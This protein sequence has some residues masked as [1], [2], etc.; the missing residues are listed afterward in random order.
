MLG[1]Y[2]YDT[3]NQTFVGTAASVHKLSQPFPPVNA[4]TQNCNAFDRN[5]SNA[6]N[7]FCCCIL[8]SVPLIFSVKRTTVTIVSPLLTITCPVPTVRYWCPV[9]VVVFEKRRNGCPLNPFE[10]KYVGATLAPVTDEPN[11]G[12]LDTLN[13]YIVL[14]LA[15]VLLLSALNKPS[16]IVVFGSQQS[17]IETLTAV[18][19]KPTGHR[20]HEVAPLVLVE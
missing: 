15:F 16:I 13:T 17:T 14:H 4:H 9:S 11:I 3:C 10:A 18:D 8:N 5:T 1:L 2:V 12:V 19:W 20:V 7:S 6:T